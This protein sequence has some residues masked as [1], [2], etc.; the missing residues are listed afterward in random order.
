M[1]CINCKDGCLTKEYDNKFKNTRMDNPINDYGCRVRI[2]G[3]LDNK[4]TRDINTS[5][6]T[7][8]VNA[9]IKENKTNITNQVMKMF[10]PD[11]FCIK[12]GSIYG[13]DNPRRKDASE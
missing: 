8:M 11:K 10:C 3:E 7:L 2:D 5:L 12:D 4:K 13:S 9:R 1:S 6:N